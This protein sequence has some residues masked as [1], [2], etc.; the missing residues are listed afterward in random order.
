MKKKDLKKKIQA[1]E[2][3]N[4][5]KRFDFN[6]KI[7]DYAGREFDRL[8]VFLSSGG[9]ALTIS[10]IEI[11]KDE[12][13]KDYRCLVISSWI[14]LF[15]ALV[16]ILSSQLTSIKSIDKE[17]EGEEKCSE[18]YN[19]ATNYLNYSSFAALIVGVLMFLIFISNTF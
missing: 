2:I 3:Q 10:Y 11:F 15:S 13:N 17:L 7:R 19:R 6:L 16:L 18:S 12:L 14:S 5:D 9:L 1:L 8:I 4:S